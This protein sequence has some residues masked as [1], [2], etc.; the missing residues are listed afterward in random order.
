MP[1]IYCNEWYLEVIQG[2]SSLAR[3]GKKML[4]ILK[5]NTQQHRVLHTPLSN[6]AC[7]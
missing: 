3:S 7:T 6:V 4:A 5:N 2:F 1:F